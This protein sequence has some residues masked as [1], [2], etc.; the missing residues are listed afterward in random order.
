MRKPVGPYREA[1]VA[2]T[3]END[4]VVYDPEEELLRL[5]GAEGVLLVRCAISKAALAA[6]EDH[7][8]SDPGAVVS[9]YLR[10]RELIQ[11]IV[12]RK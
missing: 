7:A 9:A 5:S 12:E 3:F 4:R 8:L 1:A 2:L 11:D 10:S 6:F